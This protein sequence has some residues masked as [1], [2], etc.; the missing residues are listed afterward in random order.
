MPGSQEFLQ[1][2]FD[3]FSSIVPFLDTPSKVQSFLRTAG[4]LMTPGE[5]ER[6]KDFGNIRFLDKSTLAPVYIE[7]KIRPLVDAINETGI[8]KT[9]TSCQ[10][11]FGWFQQPRFFDRTVAN[12]GFR[13]LLDGTERQI[14]SLF[15]NIGGEYGQIDSPVHVFTYKNLVFE[16]GLL[17]LFF[18]EFRVVDRFALPWVKRKHTD[19]A[20][21][22]VTDV[23]RGWTKKG[24]KDYVPAPKE[25]I[26]IWM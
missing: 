6:F 21:R 13:L 2:Q 19:N 9:F 23:V 26:D 5:D 8:G 4:V 24:M 1:E 16:V 17:Q 3:K 10:G 20:I 15:G 7:P 12:V 18:I 25:F 14:E 11:H 22:L